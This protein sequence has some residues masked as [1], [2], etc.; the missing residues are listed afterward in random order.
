MA[1]VKKV[2]KSAPKGAVAKVAESYAQDVFTSYAKQNGNATKQSTAKGN[3]RYA[4]NVNL[5][6]GVNSVLGTL[7]VFLS[8]GK[9]RPEIPASEFIESLK[10]TIEPGTP[11]CVVVEKAVK[12]Y[13][14]TAKKPYDNIKTVI[15]R[16]NASVRKGA[17]VMF[18]PADETEY[19]T[20]MG[21]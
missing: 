3:G 9:K 10:K 15:T 11:E 1:A 4:V 6:N 19:A 12:K 14:L 5:K 2:T 13:N 17:T 8:G 18:V 7:Y 20:A 16:L 21:K